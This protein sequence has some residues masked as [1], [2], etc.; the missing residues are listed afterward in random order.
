M[1]KKQLSY[2]LQWSIEDTIAKNSLVGNS[3]FISSTSFSW[4]ETL[5]NQWLSI[6]KEV[7]QLLKYLDRLPNFQD[8]SPREAYLTQDNGWKTYFFYAFGLYAQRNCERC[9]KT[10]ELLK[11]IPGLQCAF[12]SILAPGKQIP[13]HRGLYKGVLRYHLALIVPQPSDRCWIRVDRQIAHWEEGKSL[14]FDD[15][16]E[17]EICN[18]TTG[19]RVVL[20]LDIARPL[21][22][23]LSWL[24]CL[25]CRLFAFTPLVQIARSNHQKWEKQFETSTNV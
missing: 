16:F 19:Y 21:P 18:A 4:V 8:I 15:T 11:Q 10:T 20:F 25:V 2:F 14:I 7:E 17:H 13:A 9:P 12:F 24:N 23:P 3:A 6:R 22:V 1:L 5:E